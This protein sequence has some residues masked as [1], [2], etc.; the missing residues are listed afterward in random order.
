M[1]DIQ[2]LYE[3]TDIL[4]IEKPAGVAVHPDGKTK[5]ETI[6]DWFVG[7]YPEAHDVGEPLGDIARPGVVHRLDKDT[8]GV[9]LLAKT[10]DGYAHLKKQFQE[11]SVKKIYHAI[12][13]GFF[14]EDMGKVDKPIGRSPNDFRKRLAGRG[15]RGEL[16]EALTFYKVLNRFSER[17]NNFSY[18]EVSP[19][20]GRTHQIRV[21]MKF[22]Q[23]P[24]AGDE[25]YNENK[26]KPVGIDR[27]ALHA[28]EIEFKNLKGEVV[29]VCAPLPVA[30]T[31]ILC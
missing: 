12:V 25:L 5:E 19:K 27:L 15:A 29:R 11:H 8:S 1:L 31:K 17:G 21:H 22:L 3:D 20:T 16:R 14:K 6:S 18:L 26:P 4:A 23:H 24:L 2:I 30:F 10:G 13:S 28:K 9:L 7:K